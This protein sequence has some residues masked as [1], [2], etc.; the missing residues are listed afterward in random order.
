MSTP[1]SSVTALPHDAPPV[2]VQAKPLRGKPQTTNSD[3]VE[4]SS[5][6]KSAAA[7]KLE[8]RVETK[9]KATGHEQAE[10]LLSAQH[11]AAKAYKK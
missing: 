2:Q 1:V 11:A 4:I 7:R 8:T 3:M 5:A 9:R 10:H 6:A